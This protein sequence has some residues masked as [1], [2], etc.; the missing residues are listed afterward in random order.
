[1]KPI[2]KQELY[3]HLTGFLKNRGV[4]L[5]S[6]SYADG[7]KKGCS[8]LTDAINLSQKG[9]DRAKAGV[10]ESLDQMRQMIHEQTAPKKKS[11]SAPG[12]AAAS[13][14]KPQAKKAKAKKA[15]A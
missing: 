14:P 9:L 10:N 11:A 1:M 13:K 3:E 6:G 12:K 15:R 5:A 8:L 2:E 4:H 7:I